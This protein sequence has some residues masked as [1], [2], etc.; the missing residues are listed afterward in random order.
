MKISTISYLLFSIPFIP[1][2]NKPV[3]IT[4]QLALAVRIYVYQ[5]RIYNS[6]YARINYASPFKSDDRIDEPITRS[7][8]IM[9]NVL[10]V[11]YIPSKQW[12]NM[13]TQISLMDGETRWA[14]AWNETV[15]DEMEPCRKTE[16]LNRRV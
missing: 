4:N 3:S 8:Q 14:Y 15:I 2:T 10:I 9:L 1:D 5:S 6:F 11:S 16:T 13:K 12:N 7:K